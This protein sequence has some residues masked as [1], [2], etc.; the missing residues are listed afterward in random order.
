M[1]CM[2]ACVH[3]CVG[4]SVCVCICMY[5][6][7]YVC[8]YV[9]EKARMLSWLKIEDHCIQRISSLLAGEDFVKKGLCRLWW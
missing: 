2:C 1:L 4:A 7:M 9:C 5:V 6:C 8:I 3:V